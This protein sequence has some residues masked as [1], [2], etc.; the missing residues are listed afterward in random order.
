MVFN[1]TDFPD[2]TS[3]GVTE[4]LAMTLSE[5]FVDVTTTTFVT[6]QTVESFPRDKRNC[7]FKH[8]D[9]VVYGGALYTYSDCIVNCK[10]HHIMKACGCRPFF[11]PR[12]GEKEC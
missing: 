12:R 6:T 8:E 5:T 2:M 10:I 11:Y 3:G 1:P 7:I 4:V 9:N